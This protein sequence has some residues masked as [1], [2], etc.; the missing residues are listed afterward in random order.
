MNAH[1]RLCKCTV[2]G[3]S[4]TFTRH[5]D[6]RR[7]NE[8]IHKKTVNFTCSVSECREAGVFFTRKDKFMEHLATH[9]NPTAMTGTLVAKTTVDKPKRKRRRSL[10]ID[11]D[12]GP[13]TKDGFLKLRADYEKLQE[14]FRETVLTLNKLTDAILATKKD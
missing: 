12:E 3:C 7:H 6:L 13:Y 10:S 5:S 2:D 8:D 1:E 14:T 9:L 4:G 11:E